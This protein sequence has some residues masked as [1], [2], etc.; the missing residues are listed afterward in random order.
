LNHGV[1]PYR[2][3]KPAAFWRGSPATE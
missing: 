2:A 3:G 1:K